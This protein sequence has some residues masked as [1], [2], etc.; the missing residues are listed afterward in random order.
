MALGAWGS[1][2]DMGG[3]E[4]GKKTVMK[5]YYMKIKTYCNLKKN[6]S[7]PQR[8]TKKKRR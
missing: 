6:Q 4:R 1:E 8:G 3:A 2:E 7:T 5:I